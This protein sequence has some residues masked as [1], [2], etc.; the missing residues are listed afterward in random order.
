[1]SLDYLEI[2]LLFGTGVQHP[3][4]KQIL[5]NIPRVKILG[6]SSDPQEFIAQARSLSPD[7]VL[8]DLRGEKK[9]PSWLEQLVQELPQTR[10]LACSDNLEAGFIIQAAQMGIGELLPLPL[11]KSG[12]EAALNRVRITQT[13]H[14]PPGETKH[15]KILV[16]TGH[17]GGV[18]CTTVAINLAV[19]LSELTTERVALIDLGR[20]F[21]DVGNFL[22]QT[23]EYSFADLI[24]NLSDLDRYFVQHIIQ[25]YDSKLAILYGVP[26]LRDQEEIEKVLNSLF[27]LLREMYSYTVVD[28]SNWVDEIY[29]HVCTEADIIL[30]LTQFTIPDV[31]NLEILMS[32]LREWSFDQR[33]IKI[34][35][36]RYISRH[37]M[38]V[39]DLNNIIKNPVFHTLPSDYFSLMKS[40]DLAVTL[41][42]ASPRSNL[43]SAIKKLGKKILEIDR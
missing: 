6:Q 21:P 2:A 35:V 15:G 17:K 38:Q 31:K 5:E 32:M 34:V 28:L 9:I 22:N 30:M 43:W 27:P 29:L 42:S 12:L 18:G 23:S 1:M 37:L 39:G 36:N 19:A 8:V 40:M 14:Q 33:K 13:R 20:P 25:S 24:N 41:A 10:I 26:G 7:V 16:V 4:I 11:S 3:E